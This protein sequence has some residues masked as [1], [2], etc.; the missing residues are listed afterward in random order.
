MSGNLWLV[1]FD[2]LILQPMACTNHKFPLT[3]NGHIRTQ[4]KSTVLVMVISHLLISR[5][6]LTGNS[7]DDHYQS[8][9]QTLFSPTH[10]LSSFLPPYCYYR[11]AGE[12]ETSQGFSQDYCLGREAAG[13]GGGVA[14]LLTS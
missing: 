7:C 3:E 12:E 4:M 13:R 9:R 11:K 5:Y 1:K 6:S 14:G 2:G 10:F 8:K